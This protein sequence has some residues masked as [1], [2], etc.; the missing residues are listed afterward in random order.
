MNVR[1]FNPRTYTQTYIP[2]GVQGGLGAGGG[3][4]GLQPVPWVFAALH[5]CK[6]FHL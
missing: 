5:I 1:F 4:R 3:G 2:T 6:I